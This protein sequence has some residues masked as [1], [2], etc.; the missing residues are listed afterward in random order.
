[1]CNY[2]QPQRQP[3]TGAGVNPAVRLLQQQ[4][5][6]SA[7]GSGGYRVQTVGAGYGGVMYAG[8]GP[9]REEQGPSLVPPP[10]A[11]LSDSELKMAT[12]RAGAV[13][14][15]PPTLSGTLGTKSLKQMRWR[16]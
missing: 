16:V 2:Q 9:V 6:D 5:G 7:G 4:Y 3:S 1:M 15:P 11:R 10:S 14:E 8:V 12:V 13:K